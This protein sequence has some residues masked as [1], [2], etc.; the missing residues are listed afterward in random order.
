MFPNVIQKFFTQQTTSISIKSQILSLPPSF[1]VCRRKSGVVVCYS[2]PV[3]LKEVPRV[4][5]RRRLVSPPPVRRRRLIPD[6]AVGQADGGGGER[7]VDGGRTGKA[8]D[9]AVAGRVGPDETGGV[10]RVI[11][12]PGRMQEEGVKLDIV[13]SGRWV[14]KD[15]GWLYAD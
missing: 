15:L 3:V 12:I 8:T 2:S 14:Q 10:T 1:P 6:D 5:P 13:H 7:T 9:A 11:V 4:A